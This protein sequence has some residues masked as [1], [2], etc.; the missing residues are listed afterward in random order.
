MESLIA[1]NRKSIFIATLS[2]FITTS[3]VNKPAVVEKPRNVVPPSAVPAL[4]SGQR[5]VKLTPSDL[6]RPGVSRITDVGWNPPAPEQL[7]RGELNVGDERVILYVPTFGPYSTN[8]VEQHSFNNTS[9]IISVDSNRDGQLKSTEKWHTSLPVR[10]GEAMFE[11]KQIDPGGT[12]ILLEES[13]LPLAG[14]VVGKKCP[15]FEFTT[16]DGKKVSLD[17]YKGKVLLLNVWSMT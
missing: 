15:D 9:T 14:C 12:W 3:C 6:T 10:L 11:V 8:S 1:V 7:S 5:I 4:K 16:M 2:I 17:T 13:K